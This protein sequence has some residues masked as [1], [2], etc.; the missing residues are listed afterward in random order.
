MRIRWL[1][2]PIFV[3]VCLMTGCTSRTPSDTGAPTTAAAVQDMQSPSSSA[4]T[5]AATTGSPAPAAPTVSSS[6]APAPRSPTS[7]AA[8]SA[9]RASTTARPG[10]TD[11]ADPFPRN[12]FG[13]HSCTVLSGTLH[14][15]QT[16]ATIALTRGAAISTAMQIDHMVALSNAWQ[17]GA[18]QLSGEQRIDPANDPR[19]VE[20]VDGPTNEAKGDSDAASWLPPNRSYRCTYVT[21]Q[22]QV[23]T[24]Y[25]L[26]VTAAEKAV[27]QE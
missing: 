22:I 3:A 8:T 2:E 13:R 15:P 1:S 26:W 4:T 14:D 27:S 16:A 18:H 17:T 12:S 24:S 23:K 19:N 6:L 7:T 11:R 5:A 25:H 9:P 21:R 10:S 20:A